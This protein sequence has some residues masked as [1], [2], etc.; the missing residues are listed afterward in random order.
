MNRDRGLLAFCCTLLVAVAMFIQVPVASGLAGLAGALFGSDPDDRP[1]L[2]THVRPAATPE[3]PRGPGHTTPLG[4]HEL[5]RDPRP[6]PVLVRLSEQ[7]S[8]P[9]NLLEALAV[10]SARSV[11]DTAGLYWCPLEPGDRPD[12]A[13]AGQP[14]GERG[15]ERTR[16]AAAR[17]AR[18]RAQT[19][20][21]RG[22]LLAWAASTGWARRV[23]E[24]AGR[25]PD[26]IPQA[27]RTHLPSYRR[28][29]AR[30]FLGTV[31]GLALALGSVWPVDRPGADPHG[32]G[33]RLQARAGA[34]IRA[35][36]D[37]RVG[38]IG[39]DGP[40]GRCIELHH[41]WGLRSMLCG[42]ATIRVRAGRRVRGGQSV[43][44][45]AAGSA[46]FGMQLGSLRLDPR[47]LA[48]ATPAARAAE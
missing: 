9:R 24:A 27:M 33:L 16:A 34:A 20:S 4:L 29:Q 23:V 3:L 8:L 21:L 2:A 18:L 40:R 14:T 13:P 39:L 5:R 26:R 42:L 44:E 45:A 12:P 36:M 22:A 46:W 41:G 28:T 25:D 43:G 17:L 7:H 30:T 10:V 11:Q 37:G 31:E 1:P 6:D 38:W 32:G 15:L 35:P 19:G 48:P 47:A